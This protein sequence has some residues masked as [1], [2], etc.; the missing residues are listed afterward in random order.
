MVHER[1]NGLLKQ[2]L[3]CCFSF[4][5]H[6]PKYVAE[7]L[8]VVRM[9]LS[10]SAQLLD[11]PWQNHLMCGLESFFYERL[12]MLVGDRV[13]EIVGAAAVKWLLLV[14]QHRG[15]EMLSAAEKYVGDITVF[16]NGASQL[17]DHLVI[18]IAQ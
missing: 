5:R 3:I 12:P 16:L 2:R 8:N 18:F 13:Q 1:F 10:A 6:V 9:P 14:Y 17:F 4:L 15:N 11:Q 7:M